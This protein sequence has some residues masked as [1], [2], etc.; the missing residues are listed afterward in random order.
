MGKLDFV[1]VATTLM[2]SLVAVVAMTVT[3]S[4]NLWQRRFSDRQQKLALQQLNIGLL[5]R[6]V[7][8]LDTVR[9]VVS[10]Y[11]SAD[12]DSDREDSLFGIIHEA[13][14]IF[15]S[16][17]ADRL[18][19]AWEAQVAINNLK[20][21]R[22]RAVLPADHQRLRDEY[23]AFRVPYVAKLKILHRELIAATRIVG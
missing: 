10:R 2:P 1:S 6:R 12:S 5:D 8:I 19:E 20:L 7:R 11:Y 16:D 4:Q 15:P 17:L 3:A 9:G 23:E 14:A 22:M 21:A 18:Q 13:H